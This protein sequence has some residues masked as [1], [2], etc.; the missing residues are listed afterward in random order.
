MDAKAKLKARKPSRHVTEGLERRLDRSGC[1][2]PDAA[3]IRANVAPRS[4]IEF[5]PFSFAKVAKRTRYAADLKP[6]GRDLAK[7]LSDISGV[8]QPRGRANDIIAFDAKKGVPNV[9]FS[10]RD[11]V[12]RQAAGTPQESEL[13]F[14]QLWKYARKVALAPIGAV[15]HSGARSEK[16]CHAD[17]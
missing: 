17:T 16:T 9:G 10:G 2:A 7:D 11:I 3:W 1:F 8:P 13:G 5:A 14:G 12:R 4:G 15:T 6:A